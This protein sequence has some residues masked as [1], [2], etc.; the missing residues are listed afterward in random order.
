DRK[1][2]E[3]IL[4]QVTA[5]PN[6]FARLAMQESGDVNSASI[7]GL[8]QPIRYTVGDP[9]IERAV[10]ALQPNQISPIIPV[11]EQFAILKCE[12]Q[13]PARNVP[14]ETWREKLPR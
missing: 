7:G 9:A 14:L 10:F 4:R 8:I 12:N 1:K 2:A 11:G 13:L 6:D 5:Q 3:Q